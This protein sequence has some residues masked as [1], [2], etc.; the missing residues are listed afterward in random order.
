ME[1]TA[2]EEIKNLRAPKTHSPPHS[3]RAGE[4]LLSQGG[5]TAANSLGVGGRGG[6]VLVRKP[7]SF[8]LVER[9]F[10][11]SETA[12]Q[13]RHIVFYKKKEGK[14][15]KRHLTF[16]YICKCIPTLFHYKKVHFYLQIY[17]H[18]LKKKLFLLRFFVAN[19]CSYDLIIIIIIARFHQC[20]TQ[21]RLCNSFLI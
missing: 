3:S 9:Y 15:A 6:R 18:S 5:L 10:F 14:F 2:A 8:L 20:L 19:G 13:I 4:K 12:R 1:I 17:N 7:E 21:I 16:M 11:F